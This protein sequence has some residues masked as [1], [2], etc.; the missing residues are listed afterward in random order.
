MAAKSTKSATVASLVRNAAA[1]TEADFVITLAEI[2]EEGDTERITEFF[3]RLNIP[4]SQGSD[5]N[6]LGTLPPIPAVSTKVTSFED[7]EK[8]EDGIQKFL[9]RHE[10]KIKWH[11][12]HPGLDGLNNVLLLT[13][14]MMIVTNVR[15][16]R[17][18]SLL[19][20]KEELTPRD[21]FVCRELMNRTYLSFRNFLNVL[22]G[23]WMDAI[24]STVEKEKLQAQL[25]N[26]YELIDAQIRQL[27]ETHNAIEGRRQ[28]LTVVPEGFP[29]VR[30]PNYFGGDLFGRGP[31][32]AVLG[33]HRRPRPQVPGSSLLTAGQ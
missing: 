31:L 20:T 8:I 7:E 3:D 26:F 4:R 12:G 25:G 16:A 33:Q 14:E 30:P 18:V 10:R 28:E 9:D 11:A 32:E 27:E 17:L 22:A 5:E 24:T 13:R 19:R 2:F 23:D 15:L 21:W 29:P 1:R 6:L